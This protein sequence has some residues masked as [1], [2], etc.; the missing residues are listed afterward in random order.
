MGFSIKEIKYKQKYLLYLT[1]KELSG[2]WFSFKLRTNQNI[3]IP[4]ILRSVE[5]TPLYKLVNSRKGPS[6]NRITIDLN[7]NEY[8]N[9]QNLETHI[10]PP[11]LLDES[12]FVRKYVDLYL[13]PNDPF[14]IA[15]FS[16]KNLS[17][18]DLLDLST[19][20]VFDFDV[21]GLEGFDKNY[22]GYNRENNVIYQYDDTQ[23]HA[24]FTTFPEPTHF[25]SKSRNEFQ[26]DGEILN[27]SDSIS[28][29]MGEK[30]S[31]MQVKSQILKPGNV[32]QVAL[33]LSGGLSKQ[34][35]MDNIK[36][37]IEK[38]TNFAK[39][40]NKSINSEDRNQQEEKFQKMNNQKAQ[41]CS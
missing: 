22:S 16:L 11:E 7:I 35:M 41:K 9:N 26:I 4:I 31:A 13:N 28:E 27:L 5:P 14:M 40:V 34:E 6:I 3:T 23:L 12:I 20:F 2:P 18:R 39:Q 15:F 36:K 29:G 33:I 1:D 37:G 19:F 24:G 17:R 10:I 30:L 32:F 21:N 25:E 38:V 8:L